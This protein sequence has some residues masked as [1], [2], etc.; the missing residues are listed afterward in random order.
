MSNPNNNNNNNNL[1]SGNRKSTRPNRTS[2]ESGELLTHWL[3]I[4]NDFEVFHECYDI[5]DPDINRAFVLAKLPSDEELQTALADIRLLHATIQAGTT[6]QRDQIKLHYEYE[7]LV[8]MRNSIR[9]RFD[10][11]QARLRGLGLAEPGE[12][13][14]TLPQNPTI[15]SQVVEPPSSI[16]TRDQTLPPPINPPMPIPS[17]TQRLQPNYRERSVSPPPAPLPPRFPSQPPQRTYRLV[18]VE[19]A[20]ANMELEIRNLQAANAGL[21]AELDEA[22]NNVTTVVNWNN[23]QEEK[24]RARDAEIARLRAELERDMNRKN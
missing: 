1:E 5:C 21:G 20:I 18:P 10:R 24:I 9:G 15:S 2:A 17:L 22:Q 12:D 6:A 14:E 8:R 11:L 23:I 13:D 19:Q 3:N 4:A 16:R 7:R